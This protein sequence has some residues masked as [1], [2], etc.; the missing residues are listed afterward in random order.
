MQQFSGLL[1]AAFRA[2]RPHHYGD[3]PA[4][5]IH[6]RGDQV[7]P[8][9]RGVAGFQAIDVHGFIP[10][11]TVTV[12]LGDPVP[13]QAF[14]A[15]HVVDVW[16]AMNN[17]PREHRE[18]IGRTVLA[19]SVEAVDGFEMGVPQVQFFDILIHQGD[20]LRLAAGDIVG[21]RDAGVVTGVDN[22]P[23]AEVADADAIPALRTSAMT[24][25]TP[26]CPS[27]K[28]LYPR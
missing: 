15:V 20:K 28:R 12:L 26:G 16:F 6:R 21:Q 8:G 11:Q 24:R 22:Q 23:T 9:A 4:L 14:L 13:R 1:L 3:Q 10:Q 5:A 25:R 17:R 19:R 18:V 7:E 27:P 2:V